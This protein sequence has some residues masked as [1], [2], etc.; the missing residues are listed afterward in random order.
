MVNDIAEL[1]KEAGAL[2]RGEFLLSSG[3]RSSIY[4][5]VKVALTK[6]LVLGAIARAIGERLDGDVVAGVAVGGVP[7][8]VATALATGIPY[9]IIRRGE[10]GHGIAGVVIGEV[11][12]RRAILVEDVTTSG[13]SALYG[14]HVLRERGATVDRV[15]TVVDRGEGAEDL[16]RSEGIE[17]VA[18]VR[19]SELL[20]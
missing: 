19:V 8:A 3:R 2:K 5:D 6:P 7:L 15:I 16:L 11:E 14:C 10:K 17:L 1:L 18:L 12:G 20:S 9:A 4:V 13:E